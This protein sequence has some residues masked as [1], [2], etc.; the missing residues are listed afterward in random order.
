MVIKIINNDIKKLGF[1]L[2]TRAIL[3]IKFI[4]EYI[5]RIALPKSTIAININAFEKVTLII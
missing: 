3:F 4:K 5:E 2:K 1:I